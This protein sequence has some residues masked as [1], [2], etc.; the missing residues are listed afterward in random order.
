[1][2][3]DP[4]RWLMILVLSRIAGRG[5]AGPL[6]NA[7][8]VRDRRDSELLHDAAAMN[9][10]RLLGRVQFRRNLLVQQTQNHEAKNV[11]LTR[12]QFIDEVTAP[13]PSPAF[14]LLFITTF[15]S[16][17]DRFAQSHGAK[18]FQ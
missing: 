12:R 15:Q 3:A 8:Q 16:P 14:S 5:D 6:R 7:N 4:L 1:M 18:V 17:L 13:A 11:E 9:F 2:I 10:D